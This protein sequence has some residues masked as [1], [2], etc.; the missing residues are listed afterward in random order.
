M[1]QSMLRWL[2]LLINTRLQ[3][4]SVDLW[5]AIFFQSKW[6]TKEN[7]TWSSSLHVSTWMAHHP[8]PEPLVYRADHGGICVTYYHVLHRQSEKIIWEQMIMDN[9]KVKLTEAFLDL[10]T[11]NIH[12]CLLPPNTT[13]ISNQW[14]YLFHA[15]LRL[16][17]AFSESRDY[18]PTSRLHN[19]HA[20]SQDRMICMHDLPTLNFACLPDSKWFTA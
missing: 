19:I 5:R 13:I 20:Q 10:D 3:R 15:I 14:I 11:N 7:P 2:E 8:F 16:H 6:F 17:C 1:V 18:I 12:V 4:F 9:F